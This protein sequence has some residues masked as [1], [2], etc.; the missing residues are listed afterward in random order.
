MPPLGTTNPSS[1][2]GLRSG[3][4]HSNW[5]VFNQSLGIA[6][7]YLFKFYNLGAQTFCFS[8]FSLASLAATAEPWRDELM[9][10]TALCRLVGCSVKQLRRGRLRQPLIQ[11]CRSLQGQDKASRCPL[12]LLLR[13]LHFAPAVLCLSPVLIIRA[14]KMQLDRESAREKKMSAL[15]VNVCVWRA[16]IS[17]ILRAL[18]P[19]H[20]A[21]FPMRENLF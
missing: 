16:S 8:L 11:K 7:I 1:T 9:H 14:Q 2:Q 4:F 6:Q 12:G 3:S 19:I 20:R 10:R 17:V 15:N 5:K 21:L 18:I 13:P